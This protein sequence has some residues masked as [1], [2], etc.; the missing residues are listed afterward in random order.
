MAGR[1]RLPIM[2]LKS[3]PQGVKAAYRLINHPNPHPDALDRKTDA[4]IEALIE[5]LYDKKEEAIAGAYDPDFVPAV[6][7]VLIVGYDGE[8]LE[9]ARY[10]DPLHPLHVLSYQLHAIGVGGQLS[11]IYFPRSG[12]V[13]DRLAL[14]DMLGDLIH[15]AL[16][17]GVILDYPKHVIFVGFFLR[18]DLALLSD[19][20]HFREQLGNVGGKIATTRRPV[21][22]GLVCDRRELER[23]DNDRNLYLDRG[24][25]VVKV[26]ITFYDIARHAAEKTPLSELGKVI[27]LPKK[28]IKA[29]F[30]IGRMD[31]Y[32]RKKLKNFILYGIR[33]AQIPANYYAHVLK[34]ARKQ[35]GGPRIAQG[36][37]PTAAGGL[38]VQMLRKKLKEAGLDYEQVFGIKYKTQQPFDEQAHRYRFKRRKTKNPYR[39]IR[40]TFAVM[41][42]HGG[43]NE[44]YF[45]G[46]GALGTWYD[47]DL[48]GA[49]S[50]GL[51]IIRPIDYENSFE[52][53]S[54][55]DFQGDVM[56]FAW[57][58]FEFPMG[59]DK[60][61]L[62]V[63]ADKESL[64][65][66]RIG[67][68]YCT[69]PELALALRM[70][71]VIEV[72]Y[73]VIFPWLDTNQR[74]FEPFVWEIRKLRSAHPKGSVEEQY[75]KL[76]GNSLYGKT[77]QGLKEK[78]AFDTGEMT[79]HKLPE[80]GITN[81]MMAAFV[82]GFIRAVMGEI[83]RGIPPH[84]KV[85]SC[86]TDGI[87]TDAHPDELDYTGELTQRYMT[88][89][90][91]VSS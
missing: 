85:I 12:D 15:E 74:I 76:L 1:R 53:R 52:T 86:T 31:E 83:M 19:F 60:P 69:A 70:G 5:T 84:R 80:S 32:R 54:L 61:C 64:E 27:H 42:Y 58:K 78:T 49:Y 23:I 47:L 34:F 25:H 2:R 37:L 10:W 75:A 17:R 22:M 36:F 81:G 56:G 14:V 7:Q 4:E 29:P 87:L 3:L 24:E 8:W 55:D 9:K 89:L 46:L 51:L 57:V 88:L 66:P 39:Q 44:C 43:R 20:V 30:H 6:G 65:F 28:T 72:K 91:R 26:P 77:A 59:T 35:V 45:F 13:C 50:I 33:D 21:S 18:V 63:R 11:A 71:A 68:S 62:P 38:A 40:E 16:R 82:T 79:T 67:E 73:G 48:I 41:C 90:E